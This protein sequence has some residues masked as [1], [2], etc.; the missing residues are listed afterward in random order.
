MKKIFLLILVFFVLKTNGQIRQPQ[1]LGSPST[2]VYSRGTIGSDSGLVFRR[3]FP[4]TLNLTIGTIRNIPNIFIVAGGFLYQRNTTATAWLRMAKYSEISAAIDTSNKWVNSISRTLGKDSIIFYIGGTRYAIKD[5]TGGSNTD[6]LFGRQDARNNTAGAM[7]FSAAQQNFTIDTANRFEV[8]SYAGANVANLGITEG[9]AAYVASNSATT[10]NEATAIT[11]KAYLK[12]YDD[13]V[14]QYL[15]EISVSKDS[16]RILPHLGVIHID[17]LQQGTSIDSVLTWSPDFKRMRYRNASAFGSTYTASN[18]ITLSGSDFKLGGTLTGNTVVDLNNK[19]FNFSTSGNKALSL[20]VFGGIYSLGDPDNNAAGTSLLINDGIR[21]VQIVYGAANPMLSL[22]RDNSIYQMGDVTNIHNGSFFYIGDDIKMTEI[23]SDSLRFI[24]SGGT[25]PKFTFNNLT[26]TS[27]WLGY[28]TGAHTGT[29]TYTLQVDASGNIIEG[30][31]VATNYWSLASGGTLTG[32]NTITAGTNPIIFSTGV[33]TGTGATAGHQIV[34]NSLTTG[35]ALDISSTS[36]SSGSIVN[37]SSTSTAAA[38]GTQKGLNISFSGINATSSQDTYGAYISNTHTGTG[39][40]NYALYATIGSSNGYAIYGNAT[41]GGTGIFGFANTGSGV[42]GAT[43]NG[44]KGVYGQAQSVT[45]GI[46]VYGESIIATG[47][48]IGISGAALQAATTNIG[49]K[50]VAT[51]GT[52]NYAI[53]VPS[54]SGSVG[55]GNSAPTST[56]DVSGGSFALNYVAKTGTYTI[57]ASDYT[58]DCTSNTFTVTL[59]TAA[60]ITGRIYVIKNSGAGTITI[61]TTS[62]QTIDGVTTQTLSTQ[63]SS[64]TVQ[65]NGANWII[66]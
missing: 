6:S 65:S 42:G 48:G 4:D 26:G 45:G 51:G 12:S 57:T 59:P 16:I 37:I 1:S 53:I 19:T 46:G 10:W 9:V 27:R 31:N 38:S 52:N 41:S 63:Y 11:T 3:N 33:T 55:I 54:A 47:T 39:H 30:A 23:F 66:L 21:H 44:G 56:L 14:A 36:V 8:F 2:D 15:S 35:N 13:A 22:D 40:N 5:S 20:D 62:S 58:I 24:N 25:V 43:N 17:S 29:P 50:F 61:A 49:G 7:Y 18:G 28:G 60:S 64:Y 34:A 32:T